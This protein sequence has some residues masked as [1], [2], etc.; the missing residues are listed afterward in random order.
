MP[1][2]AVRSVPLD[3][4]SGATIRLVGE[5]DTETDGNAREPTPSTEKRPCQTNELGLGRGRRVMRRGAVG[6]PSDV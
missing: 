6:K 4:L 2:C 5:P 1:P 3:S